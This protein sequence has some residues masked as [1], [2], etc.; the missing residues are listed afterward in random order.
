MTAEIQ[1]M[2]EKICKLERLIYECKLT[3]AASEAFERIEGAVCILLK[4][5][6][7]YAFA[8]EAPGLIARAALLKE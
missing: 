5:S 2:R 3:D 4:S 8:P 1:A 7:L 6:A